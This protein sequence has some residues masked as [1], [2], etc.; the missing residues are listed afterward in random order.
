MQDQ[1]RLHQQMAEEN[2]EYE[3]NGVSFGFEENEIM[4]F[5]ARLEIIT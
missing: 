4:S 1:P 5:A 3:H 2:V